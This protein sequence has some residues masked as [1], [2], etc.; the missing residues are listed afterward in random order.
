MAEACLKR[1][2]LLDDERGRGIPAVVKYGPYLFVAGSD[3]HRDLETEKVIP[4]LYN[5]APEQCRNAYGR[6]ARRLE[7]AG[8]SGRCAVWAQNF[9]SGQHWRLERMATWP[10]HFGEA[11]HAQVVSFGS[12]C[13]MSGINM[14]TATVMAMTPDLPRQVGV[15]Q[16]HRGRASRVT[17]CGKLVFVIGVRGRENFLSG[18]PAPE[19]VPEAFP[20]QLANSY[21]NLQ[22]HMRRCGGDEDAFVR[23]DSCIR[24]IGRIADW[25]Q[26]T[27]SRF[28][29]KIPFAHYTVGTILGSRGE[30]EVGA[31]AVAPGVP[32]DVAWFSHAPDTA[33]ATRGGDLVFVTACSG[34][35]N[36]QGEIVDGL[37]G[38]HRGQVRQAIEN[39][40]AGLARFDVG[41]E[42]LLRMDIYVRDIYFED[43]LVDEIRRRLG[44]DTPAITV[45]S[46]APADGAVVEVTAIAGAI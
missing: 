13:W 26:V 29:G 45:V 46:G 3:G 17:R 12:Q 7:K 14:L 18:E 39:L 40:E 2:V 41:P 19:E 15:P 27:T 28:G 30:M 37:G 8:Y 10:D 24:D 35:R 31:V 6:V 20:I 33:Q 16:P 9:T 22:S 38:D 23:V 21:D 43:E 25:H 5:K 44:A 32:K 1:E 34:L 36:T 11:E 42:R 4:D